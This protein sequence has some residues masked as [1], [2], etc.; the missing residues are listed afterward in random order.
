MSAVTNAAQAT[1][2]RPHAGP[3]GATQGSITTL[4]RI[5]AG[6]ALAGSIM[7]YRV[8]G[9]GWSMLAVLFL[10][11]DLSMLGY[12]VSRRFGAAAYNVG[13]TYLSP[14]ALAAT[15]FAFHAPITILL[16]L[17]WAAHISFD[18]LVG[19]GL[20]YP[21]AFGATHLGWVGKHD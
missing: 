3:L 1:A 4:L 12:L 2:D 10:V 5:E 13:H 15:G 6:L 19:Y 7:A 9:G 14:A 20:K 16:A 18:R 17:I 21:Q 8:M 11:P